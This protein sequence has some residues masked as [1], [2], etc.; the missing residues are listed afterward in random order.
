MHGNIWEFVADFYQTD[1]YTTSPTD[2]P[3]GPAKGGSHGLRG[4]CWGFSPE[5]GRS[6]N[7]GRAN[8]TTRGYRDGFRVVRE[9]K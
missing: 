4:S 3:P 2:D 1:F 8:P 9:I 6:A 7:R 5:S